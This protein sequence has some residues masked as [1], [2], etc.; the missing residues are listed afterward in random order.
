[1][2]HGT[3]ILGKQ[4]SG[5][6][7][8]RDWHGT[9][10]ST[11]DEHDYAY[12]FRESW[13]PSVKYAYATRPNRWMD[14][15]MLTFSPRL[16]QSSTDH[17]VNLINCATLKVQGE[18]TQSKFNLGVFAGEFRE[19][20]G[21]I[22]DIVT[23]FAKSIAYAK[24]GRF[25]KAMNVLAMAGPKPRSLTG[26]AANNY[27]MWHFG[28]LPLCNDINSFYELM[29][30][31]YKKLKHVRRCCTYKEDGSKSANSVVWHW[32]LKAVVEIRGDVEMIDL[33]AMDRLGLWDLAGTAWELSKLSWL[34]DWLIPIGNFLS[35]INAHNQT[36]GTMFAVTRHQKEELLDPAPTGFYIFKNFDK[37]SYERFCNPGAINSRYLND[38][39]PLQFPTIQNP[40]GDNLSRWVTATAFLRQSVGR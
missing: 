18:L 32:Q 4:G 22:C 14:G 11:A 16:P 29:L 23:A 17:T 19:S 15:S 20:Y 30:H 6:Y 7:Q 27:M 36:R 1:M 25:D 35:A 39:L 10:G 34:V 5:F 31:K 9:D 21:M 24:R 13:L 26:V 37:S 28:I 3:T 8:Y 33:N 2:T 38:A 40:L 12:S